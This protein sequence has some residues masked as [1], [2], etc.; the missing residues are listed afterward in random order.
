MLINY[1]RTSRTISGWNRLWYKSSRSETSNQC[2]EV[3]QHHDRVGVSD[4]KDRGGPE[5]FFQ[6]SQ[7]DTFLHSHI[8]QC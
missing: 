5:L 1:L 8:W 3:Y 7:W 4:S 2:V 6:G